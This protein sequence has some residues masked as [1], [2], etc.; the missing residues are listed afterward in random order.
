MV[1][2]GLTVLNGVRA[3]N[4]LN[5]LM[6]D[7]DVLVKTRFDIETFKTVPFT[8]QKNSRRR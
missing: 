5:D 2:Q 6:V 3:L 7:V 1:F 4:A 8:H